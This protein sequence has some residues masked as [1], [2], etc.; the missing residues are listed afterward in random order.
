MSLKIELSHISK[1]FKREWIL[2]DISLAFEE[3]LSYAVSGPN[4]SGKS[5]LLRILAAY[6]TPSKGQLQFSR[7]GRK[8]ELSEVYQFLS[9]AAPYIDLIGELTLTEMIRFHQQ[10][11]SFQENLSPKE[12]IELLDMKSSRNKPVKN[13]SS[14]M[15]Q[16]LKLVLNIC[17]DTPILLLDEPTS[18]LDQ[19]GVD[20]YLSL[21]ERFRQDRLVVVASNVPTD[22]QFCKHLINIQDYK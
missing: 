9:Y 14:G 19:Q 20:W 7:N 4:G 10:F 18:N 5:T 8:L 16:R 2:K 17:T 21:I 3:G 1:R 6:L 15:K 12:V 22:F 13:F 11:K